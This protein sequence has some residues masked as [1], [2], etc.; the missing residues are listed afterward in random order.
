M[1]SGSGL[2]AQWLSSELDGGVEFVTQ[3]SAGGDKVASAK[4]IRGKRERGVCGA[5]AWARGS[6][7]GRSDCWVDAKKRDRYARHGW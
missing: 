6:G 5:A 4:W 3:P 2:K 7:S 1:Q